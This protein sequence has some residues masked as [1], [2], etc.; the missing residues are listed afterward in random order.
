MFCSLLGASWSA[1][2]RILPESRGFTGPPICGAIHNVP[3]ILGLHVGDRGGPLHDDH[4]ADQR[5]AQRRGQVFFLETVLPKVQE[6][7]RVLH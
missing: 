2:T 5:P 4:D 6:A 1:I 7:P 3:T